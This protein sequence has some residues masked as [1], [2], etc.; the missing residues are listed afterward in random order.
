M[1]L[2]LPISTT[3]APVQ[4]APGLILD[5][6]LYTTAATGVTKFLPELGQLT[7]ETFT[8]DAWWLVPD[9]VTGE[10]YKAELTLV[11]TDIRTV[12]LT[13]WFAA[14]QRSGHDPKPHNHPWDFHSMMLE[15]GYVESRWT[16]HDGVVVPELDVEHRAG[17][18][19]KIGREVFHR[20][21]EVDPGRTMTLMMCGPG[22][23]GWGYLDPAD[24]QYE[25]ATLP[26]RFAE[27]QRA[28]NPHKG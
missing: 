7:W 6:K 26:A 21:I 5:D 16:V 13:R 22:M 15:S 17:T 3:N 23:A 4:I 25:A 28:L 14:D 12:K 8:S 9:E 2:N 27:L 24:G 19:N 10:A 20:I 1:N 18:V 11:K